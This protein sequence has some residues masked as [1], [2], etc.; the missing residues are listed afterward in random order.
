M[1]PIIGG[2]ETRFFRWSGLWFLG[3]LISGLWMLGLY[4]LLRGRPFLPSF[5]L[6][7]ASFNTVKGLHVSWLVMGWLGMLLAGAVLRLGRKTATSRAAAE[8]AAWLWMVWGAGSAILY[9]AHLGP[10]WSFTWEVAY[11]WA[12]VLILVAAFGGRVRIP[13][14]VPAAATAAVIALAALLAP[15]PHGHGAALALPSVQTFEVAAAAIVAA[16][17]WALLGRRDT[18][19]WVAACLAWVGATWLGGLM[20]LAAAGCVIAASLWV[21]MRLRVRAQ[22]RGRIFLG[23]AVVATAAAGLAP[24]VGALLTPLV[25]AATLSSVALGA[26][27]IL[28]APTAGAWH[29]TSH[30]LGFTALVAG[31][32]AAASSGGLLVAILIWGGALA[33]VA[34]ASVFVLGLSRP[35]RASSAAPRPLSQQA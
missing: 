10:R 11:G 19:A 9:L 33:V 4:P 15:T 3:G 32:Q 20:P 17:T 16:V 25:V 14:R 30:V 21:M 2:V 22:G 29:W 34:G 31:L 12:W 28:S 27:Y 23:Y 5:A 6:Q 8:T 26:V 13:D 1:G 18:W 7:F 35:T 24:A